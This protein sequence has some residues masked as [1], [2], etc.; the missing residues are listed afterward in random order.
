[1]T[2]LYQTS[3]VCR[4]TCRGVCVFA[5]AILVPHVANQVVGHPLRDLLHRRRGGLLAVR[6]RP[7]LPRHHN[8][9][10][11]EHH[12]QSPVADCE[13]GKTC[14][15][16]IDQEMAYLQHSRLS[17]PGRPKI[18]ILFSAQNVHFLSKNLHLYI[19]MKTERPA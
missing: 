1:M 15:R 4:S 6:F 16:L 11:L 10:R 19:K 17:P 14:R 7:A 3:G 8:S 9:V 18:I 12:L 13:I 5:H 2:F